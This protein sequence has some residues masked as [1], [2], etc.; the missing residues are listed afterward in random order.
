MKIV[1]G[2]YGFPQAGRLANQLLKKRLE[3]HDFYKVTH[4]P[5]LFTHRAIPIW[6]ALCVDNCG[7]K[8][9][10]KVVFSNGSTLWKKIAKGSYIAKPGW[11]GTT[12]KVILTF[13]CQITYTNNSPNMKIP[14][15][16]DNII[17]HMLQN[18][19]NMVSRRKKLR[20]NLTVRPSCDGQETCPTSCRQISLLR[21]N[22]RPDNFTRT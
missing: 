6:F 17:V 13:L 7:V 20:P 15:Q 4:M 16:R 9:A 14:H 2:L 21:T 18:Q 11:I 12:Q 22:N 3:E 8:Y 1:R 10:V 5:C 19:E